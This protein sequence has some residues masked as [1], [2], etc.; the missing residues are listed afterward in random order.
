M[1]DDRLR[2]IIPTLSAV[3]VRLK[4]LVEESRVFLQSSSFATL[5]LPPNQVLGVCWNKEDDRII[6][7]LGGTLFFFGISLYCNVL[8]LAV[9]GL[10]DGSGVGGVEELAV[11][12]VE[13]RLKLVLFEM[14]RQF[15]QSSSFT[16]LL[17]SEFFWNKVGAGKVDGSRCQRIVLISDY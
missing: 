3:S 14:G 17:T 9:A 1:V 15:L 2:E 12:T 5:S 8:V 13:D 7:G 11:S 10:N 16:T 6:L 4:L